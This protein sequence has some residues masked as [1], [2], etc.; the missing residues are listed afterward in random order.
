VRRSTQTEA[1]AASKS[2]SR[3]F[4]PE[5]RTAS[6]GRG[7]APL[8]DPRTRLATALPAGALAA[9]RPCSENVIP[10]IGSI[11]KP[12][13]SRIAI[14]AAFM[15]GGERFDASTNRRGRRATTLRYV[16]NGP[17]CQAMWIGLSE[18]RSAGG[19]EQTAGML[20]GHLFGPGGNTTPED[21]GSMGGEYGPLRRRHSGK[22][23]A[24]PGR[25]PSIPSRSFV[26]CAQ[27]HSG[28]VAE[29]R[30]QAYISGSPS[31]ARL[32]YSQEET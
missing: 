31:R 29:C 25:C 2:W 1:P 20:S 6:R 18:S 7:I 17:H 32:A 28:P 4:L 5:I 13:A 3:F 14:A 12:C 23:R 19:T 26:R 8:P 10:T 24:V 16:A 9:A 22:G 15:A 30:K 27:P 21:I 11:I